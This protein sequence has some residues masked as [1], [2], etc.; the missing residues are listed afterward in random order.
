MMGVKFHHFTPIIFYFFKT[1]RIFYVKMTT[2]EEGGGSSYPQL[3]NNRACQ[4]YIPPHRENPDLYRSLEVKCTQLGLFGYQV[5]KH[6]CLGL[7]TNV[8][9]HRSD[10]ATQVFTYYIFFQVFIIVRLNHF[11]R[12]SEYLV[13]HRFLFFGFNLTNGQGEKSVFLENFENL[14]IVM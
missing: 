10:C 5:R 3:G 14:K 9:H 13:N 6:S 1:L 7:Y 2:S 8:P 12:E 4:L 11:S